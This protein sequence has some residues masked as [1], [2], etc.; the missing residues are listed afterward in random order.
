MKYNTNDLSKILDVTTNTIRRYE[1]KGFL[2]PER[3]DQN[4]Y[5]VFDSGELEKAIY[6]GRYR[7]MGFDHND[8]ANLFQ[9]NMGMGLRRFQV[10]MKE[11]DEKISAL[12]ATRHMLND[13][14]ILM[15][16]G[17][18]NKGEIF[19]KNCRA[20]YYILYHKNGRMNTEGKNGEAY[21]R[22][23]EECPEIKYIYIFD[24][25][26]VENENLVYSEGIASN[27]IFTGLYDVKVE[28]PI[29]YY[30]S[31]PSLMRF[32]RIPIDMENEG[33]MSR[34]DIKKMLFGDFLAYIEQNNFKITGDM[35][36]IKIGF[37]REEDKEWQYVFLNLPVEKE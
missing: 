12:M 21:R 37:S 6:I 31:C 26:N 24:K 1:D 11:L 17:T 16:R 13:D 28:P 36:G 29:R 9:E 22:F 23:V 15:E 18:A 34:A 30:E 35:I 5:R 2:N 20:F 10:K 33:Q 19:E 27:E 14:I 8:I 7:K 3:N 4:G 32:A 25:E